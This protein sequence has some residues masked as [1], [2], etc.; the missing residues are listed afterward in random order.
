M[1]HLGPDICWQTADMGCR[2]RGGREKEREKGRGRKREREV[3]GGGLPRCNPIL[4][5][6]VIARELCGNGR[7]AGR[8][9]K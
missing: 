6:E 8:Q 1:G 3:G 5:P 7:P 9:L 2:E 4:C